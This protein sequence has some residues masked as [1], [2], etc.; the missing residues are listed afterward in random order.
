MKKSPENQTVDTAIIEIQALAD[1]LDSTDTTKLT[2]DLRDLESKISALRSFILKG[3]G[4]PN[5]YR[6]P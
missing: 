3:Q 1:N 5:R 4:P 2:Y 6:R